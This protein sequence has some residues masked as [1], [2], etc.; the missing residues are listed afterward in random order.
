MS[1]VTNI[2]DFKDFLDTYGID[3][4]KKVKIYIGFGNYVLDCPINTNKITEYKQFAPLFHY[5]ILYKSLYPNLGSGTVVLHDR[6]YFSEQED[7]YAFR[8]E[9][10]KIKKLREGFLDVLENLGYSKE[11]SEH[12]VRYRYELEEVITE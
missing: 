5:E 1:R 2:P 10:K 12:I 4:V 8:G 11:E 7:M 9:N 3:F 6:D